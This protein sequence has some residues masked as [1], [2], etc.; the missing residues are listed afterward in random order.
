MHSA[1]TR[2]SAIS[3]II[4]ERMERKMV[5]ISLE[6]GDVRMWLK[7]RSILDSVFGIGLW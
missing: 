2:N 3:E 1:K 5:Q 6:F 4:S 7:R